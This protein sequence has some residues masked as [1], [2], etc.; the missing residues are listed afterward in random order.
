MDYYEEERKIAGQQD[1]KNLKDREATKT[2]I[3]PVLVKE[4]EVEETEEETEEE[5]EEEDKREQK[6]LQY[7]EN[8]NQEKKD[9]PHINVMV[10]EEE[11]EE[12]TG[13]GNEEEEDVDNETVRKLSA[14]KDHESQE[15]AGHADTKVQ[16]ELVEEDESEDENEEEDGRVKEIEDDSQ[17]TPDEGD[18]ILN[19]VHN[20]NE[21]LSSKDETEKSANKEDKYPEAKSINEEEETQEEE[22]ETQE[23]EEEAQE[24]GEEAQEEGEEV[25]EEGEEAPEEGEE[26]EGSERK[27][28]FSGRA[29]N[30]EEEN[31]NVKML[32]D[33]DT[34]NPYESS[35]ADEEE[36]DEYEDEES[37]NQ[38]KQSKTV[39]LVSQKSSDKNDRDE[40][41]ENDVKKHNDPEEVDE[42]DAY[43]E[44]IEDVYEDER[45]EKTPFHQKPE[46]DTNLTIESKKV[47]ENIVLEEKA[48]D[49]MDGVDNMS[50]KES[51]E[52]DSEYEEEYEEENKGIEK[53]ATSSQDLYKSTQINNLELNKED[54]DYDGGS[55]FTEEK[56]LGS[57][58]EDPLDA[59]V[60]T[61]DGEDEENRRTMDTTS[62]SPNTQHS[63]SAHVSI[64]DTFDD[65]DL[66]VESSGEEGSGKLVFSLF[67]KMVKGNPLFTLFSPIFTTYF[68]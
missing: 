65:E 38:I 15:G 18:E 68:Y 35:G 8:M 64:A 28:S 43:D 62:T 13:E 19:I 67:N 30:A 63:S 3:I 46:M 59:S 61:T 60:S 9:I 21:E 34:K 12:E 23:E 56:K 57:D 16:P 47:N 44:N 32:E 26:E 66:Y 27:L 39:E 5:E 33:N 52:F 6:I 1:K 50:N 48:E 40:D 36:E 29:E 42:S 55:G 37:Y 2:K 10:K 51:E 24:E 11:A 14:Q 41:N 20:K 45:D 31:V 4:E 58:I 17:E 7:Q 49:Y 53:Q 25:Q 54:L 22:E